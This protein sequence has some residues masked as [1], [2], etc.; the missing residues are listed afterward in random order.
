MTARSRRLRH[1]ISRLAAG[2]LLTIGL[3]AGSANAQVV[4]V[5]PT[6]EGKDIAEYGEQ[7]KRWTD[8]LKQYQQQLDHYNQQLI[9]LQRLK[10]F[11]GPVMVD[12]FGERPSDYGLEEDCPGAATSGIK[13]MI[14]EQL[15]LIAPDMGGG[16]VQEQMK[17]CARI[18]MAKNAQYNESVRMIRRLIERNNDFKQVEKQRDNGGTSEGALA[19]NNN[20]VQRFVARNAMDLDYWQAQMKAYD[21]YIV[22]LKEDQTR[23]AKAAMD[24]GTN[25]WLKPL[26]QVVQAATLKKALS[27]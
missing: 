13:G 8:T 6:G 20:E 15:T 1:P 16:L 26:G 12:N 27:N 4:V 21:S 7:A 14:M 10:N 11:R 17:V 19:A 23:L 25:S 9:K 24:G 22:A 3:C 2:L 18:V 5:N